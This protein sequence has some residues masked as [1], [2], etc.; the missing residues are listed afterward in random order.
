MPRAKMLYLCATAEICSPSEWRS[1][2]YP[3]SSLDAMSF[4][5]HD[6][7]WLTSVLRLPFDILYCATHQYHRVPLHPTAGVSLYVHLRPRWFSVSIKWRE[8]INEQNQSTITNVFNGT[9]SEIWLS[10]G[11]LLVRCHHGTQSGIHHSMCDNGTEVLAR[12]WIDRMTSEYRA[13]C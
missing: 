2:L 7:P 6:R 10:I 1:V 9:L 11:C 13:K 4:G 3:A 5:N 8:P 12:T